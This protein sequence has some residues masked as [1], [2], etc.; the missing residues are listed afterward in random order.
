M[1]CSLYDTSAYFSVTNSAFRDNSAIQAGGVLILYGESLSTIINNT[2]T[3]NSATDYGG[4]IH[5]S[6]GSFN[7]NNSNFNSNKA[8]NYG[9]IIFTIGC[10]IH[11]ANSIFEHNKGSLYIFNR[12]SLSVV[13]QVWKTELSHPINQLQMLF[14]KEEQSQASNP[15]QPSLE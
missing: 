1:H 10:S 9:G 11:I 6:S 3:N 12:T 5:C 2:F 14:Q 7:I 15:L 13:T 8:D 4:V